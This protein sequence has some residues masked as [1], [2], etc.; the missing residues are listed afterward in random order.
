M[1][2]KFVESSI[3]FISKYEECDD[4]KLKKLRYGLQGIYSLIVKLTAVIIISIITKTY[5][6]TLLFLLFYA[7]LRTFSY[8]MHAKSNIGCWV[9]TI[10]IYNV[11]PFIIRNYSIPNIFSYIVLGIGLVSMILWAPADT[12]KKPLIRKKQRLLCKGVSITVVIIYII[13]FLISNTTIVN[14]A[15]IY[16]LII[17]SIIINPITYKVTNTKF[18]NYKYYKKK[19][20]AV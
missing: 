9:T 7:G 1:K 8:G 3:N 2:E 15:I 6:E 12:P 4:L 19:L 10:T 20:N 16:A 11:I 14:N 5:K 13:I 17:Q 18:N